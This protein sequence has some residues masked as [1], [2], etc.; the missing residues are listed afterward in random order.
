MTLTEVSYWT[1]RAGLA[2]TIV[3][4]LFIPLRLVYLIAKSGAPIQLRGELPFASQGYGTLPAVSLVGLELPENVTPQYQLETAAGEFPEVPP[5][6][7]VYDLPEKR[8]SLTTL[9]E[10][11]LLAA[12]MN[13]DSEPI[14]EANT[15]IYNWTDQI[16]RR[17]RYDASTQNFRLST[18][19]T[20]DVYEDVVVPTTEEA[21]EDAQR[22]LNSLKLLSQDYINGFQDA[23]YLKFGNNGEYLVANSQSEAD[24]VRVDFFREIQ[25]LQLT[26]EE[27]QILE[28]YRKKEINL[29]PED[30]PE[31]I[32]TSIITEDVISSNIYV[33]FRN[34]NLS[35]A[36]AIYELGHTS[37]PIDTSATETYYTRTPA[38]AWEDV[39]NGNAHLR[40]LVRQGG[41]PYTDYTPV[42]VEQ[43]LIYEI[44]MVYLETEAAQDYLQPVYLVRGEAREPGDPGKPKLEFAFITSAVKS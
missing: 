44:T 40:Y 37:W 7:Q 43:F 2:L 39:K 8:Q 31:P 24:L 9:D 16:G 13:F 32:I 34:D 27:K 41:E 21:K 5:V 26:D 15:S 38:E 30:V 6:V 23:T 3:L 14:R 17:L 28:K 33:I 12:K 35:Q 36:G 4:L 29:D 19:F 10:A 22:Y 18:D 25:M 11:K 20:K 1:K 42:A